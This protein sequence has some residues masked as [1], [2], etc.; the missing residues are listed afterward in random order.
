MVHKE[1]VARACNDKQIKEELKLPS[2][3]FGNISCTHSLSHSFIPSL[4]LS[5]SLTLLL[6]LP[7]SLRLL[8][9]GLVSRP[10][11]PP[12][13]PD[14]EGGAERGGR[15]DVSEDRLQPGG[16]GEEE[17]P[18]AHLHRGLPGQGPQAVRLVVSATAPT[19]K[20]R[21]IPERLL[22]SSRAP[23]GEARC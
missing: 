1:R 3:L 9:R 10:G 18:P 20:T 2:I 16:H 12:G 21:N 23:S 6:S 8:L 5:P 19:F 7:P 22:L 15:P 11:G 4:S 13:Q 14:R 17:R